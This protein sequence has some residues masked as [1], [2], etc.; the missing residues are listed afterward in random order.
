MTESS[1]SSFFVKGNSHG[2]DLTDLAEEATEGILI[3]AESE[4]SNEESVWLSSFSTVLHSWG[5]VTSWVL[6]PHLSTVE[7]RLILGSESLSSG[8]TLTVFNESLTLWLSIWFY[9]LDLGELTEL[10]EHSLESVLSGIE[11]ES[12]NE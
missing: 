12:L 4:V 9:E 10:S 8:N 5:S 3:G 11:G 1:W 7:A 2:L 6:D